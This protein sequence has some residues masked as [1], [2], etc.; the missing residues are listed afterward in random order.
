MNNSLIQQ[1]VNMMKKIGVNMS[2]QEAY[3]EL[4]KNNFI[5]GYFATLSI[6]IMIICND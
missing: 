4:L 1:T 5:G 3:Q 6:V 2:E